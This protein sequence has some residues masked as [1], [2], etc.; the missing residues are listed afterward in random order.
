MKLPQEFEIR[1]ARCRLRCP[2][3]SDMAHV[4]SATRYA[5]FNDGMGWNAPLTVDELLEPLGKNLEAWAAGTAFSFTIELQTNRAFLGRIAIRPEEEN[6]VWNI[7]YFM[8]PEHQGQGYMSV[9]ASAILEFGF[10]QLEAKRIEARYAVWNW[11][12]GHVLSRIG[13]R[14]VRL[15]PE[16]LQKNGKVEDDYLTAIE[17]ADWLACSSRPG[18]QAT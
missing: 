7:G 10:G 18:A 5:G 8:H 12:S 4:F 6:G 13:M 11:R 14:V 16:V 3:E 9:A 15:I 2:S 1:T 17:R